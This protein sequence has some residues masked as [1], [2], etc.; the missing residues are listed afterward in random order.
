MRIRS[1][2]R[3]RLAVAVLLLAALATAAAAPASASPPRAVPAHWLMPQQLTWYWQLQG[4]IM[5]GEPVEAYDVDGF[6]TSKT[7]VSALREKGVHVICYIDVGTAEDFRPDYGE[8]PKSLLGRSNGWPGERWIDIRQLS[9]VEPIMFAR[10]QMCAEKGFQAVEP[11]NIEAYANRSGFPITA[12]QQLTFNT[13]VAEAV[14][15]LGMAVLQKNDGQQSGEL[16][17]YFDGALSEQCNQYSECASFKAYLAAGKPMLNAEYH[18]PP[19]RF[20][21]QDEAAGIMGAR[22]NVALN[23]ARYQ[24]CWSEGA[25]AARVLSTRTRAREASALAYSHASPE[26]LQPQAAAG[27]CR[28]RGGG[29]YALPDAHCTPGALNP[30]VTQADIHSTIC[31]SGWTSRVRPPESISESEKFAS[32]R[33]YGVRGYASEYEYDH[34]VPLELGGAPNDPRNLW[35]ELDYSSHSGYY[36]NPKD[37]LEY[38]LNGLVC[39]GQMPLARA[40]QLIAE[41]WVAAYR[42]YG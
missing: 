12:Q 9:I 40:Q 39:D 7:Q 36:L 32:M 41:D 14:H 34:L 29:L 18:L 1:P 25:A 5:M 10:F 17:P 35:P 38:A 37:R 2:G 27:S 6:E 11:D 30:A 20:C 8:F 21:A 19:K 42:A 3:P 16:E 22:F 31:A 28:A 26:V 4:A 33:A 15:S 13:W 23:G 24:P